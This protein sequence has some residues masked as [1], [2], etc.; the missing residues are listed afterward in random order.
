MTTAT[1]KATT[2]TAQHQQRRRLLQQRRRRQQQQQQQVPT[3]ESILHLK[4]HFTSMPSQTLNRVL[5]GRHSIT[6]E[7]QD[8]FFSNLV[9]LTFGP[10]NFFF[11]RW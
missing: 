7:S 5:K 6:F 8:T 3:R 2:T 9:L 1:T 11:Y 10:K 4:L